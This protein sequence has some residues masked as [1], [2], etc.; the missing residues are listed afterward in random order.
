[1]FARANGQ[2]GLEDNINL[3][4]KEATREDFKGETF[5]YDKNLYVAGSKNY[6]TQN[7]SLAERYIFGLPM[8]RIRRRNKLPY[9]IE[10]YNGSYSVTYNFKSRDNGDISLRPDKKC[11]DIVYDDD[12]MDIRKSISFADYNNETLGDEVIKDLFNG[13]LTTKQK[14]RMRRVQFGNK[15]LKYNASDVTS[16]YP[17]VP[18]KALIIPFDKSY[19]PVFP[20]GEVLIDKGV[21]EYED[22]I[23]RYGAKILKGE[24]LR[25]KISSTGINVK[26]GTFDFWIKPFFNGTDKENITIFELTDIGNNPILTLKKLIQNLY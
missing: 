4:F 1:M 26:E 7:K 19:A 25:Y 11:Y 23:H 14:V 13:K 20:V 8:F 22:S 10:N 6:N 16:V 15:H 21:V 9:S 5:N 24:N 18:Q 2:Y 3:A 17:E 12:I